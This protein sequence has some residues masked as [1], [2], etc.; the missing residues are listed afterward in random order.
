MHARRMSKA[1]RRL[2]KRRLGPGE[3]PQTE[4]G[5]AMKAKVYQVSI[6]GVTYL[7]EALTLAGATRDVVEEIGKKMRERAV[8]DLATGE[9]LYHAGKKGLPVINGAQYVNVDD[10]EQMGLTGIPETMADSEA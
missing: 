2:R 10:P 8:V 5:Q 4:K 9:Q 7:V 3:R 1:L 6:D